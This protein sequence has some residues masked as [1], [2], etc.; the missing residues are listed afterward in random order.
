M[1]F[2]EGSMRLLDDG[3]S[4]RACRHVVDQ[5]RGSPHFSRLQTFRY[6]L[7]VGAEKAKKAK[8]LDPKLG[9]IT[10]EGLPRE[11]RPL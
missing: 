9:V 1:A 2:W 8:P 11:F 3:N 7:Q 10:F 4:K 5:R 6:E